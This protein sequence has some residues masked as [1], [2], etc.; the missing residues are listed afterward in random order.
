MGLFV[1]LAMKKINIGRYQE[2]EIW[3]DIIIK[4]MGCPIKIKRRLI[5]LADGKCEQCGSDKSLFI[6]KIRRNKNENKWN[7]N[8]TNI[9]CK[10][11]L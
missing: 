8:K 9:R 5:E 1:E 2:V 4:E 11:S 10:N 6:S 3:R 7:N